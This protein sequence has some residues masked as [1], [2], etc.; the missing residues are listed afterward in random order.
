MTEG[1]GVHLPVA[2]SKAILGHEGEMLVSLAVAKAGHHYRP[3]SGLDFGV[4][5]RIEILRPDGKQMVATGREIAVQSKRGKGVMQS[6]RYGRTYYF[7]EAHANYWLGHSLPVIVAHSWEGDAVRWAPVTTDTVRKTEHG[8]A[9][10]L[11]EYSDLASAG[12]ELAKL[13]DP[14]ARKA[15]GAR[16]ET[17]LIRVSIHGDLTDDPEEIGLGALETSRKMIRGVSA[18]VEV[19]LE[20]T[21]I[22]IAELDTLADLESPDGNARRRRMQ[23]EDALA[24]YRS[25]ADFL[26]RAVSLLLGSKELME[27]F[28]NDDHALTDALVTLLRD[29][30]RRDGDR[31]ALQTWPGSRQHAL[32]VG[33]DVNR[34]ELNEMFARAPELAGTF[35]LADASGFLVRDLPRSA[36]QS[37]L[38]PRLARRFVNYAI[39]TGMADHEVLSSSRMDLENW[40]VGLA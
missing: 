1:V 25:K 15:S 11:P 17:F 13:A 23:F 35:R 32:V 24:A 7:S 6:T 10:D 38:L 30:A 28:G 8:Y 26:T 4:D 40:M 18:T 12:T 37:G 27:F 33:F 22:L 2:S 14:T 9:I 36:I 3:N 19:E 21:D 29:Q 20:G 39:T 34:A 16:T 31:T 5:G